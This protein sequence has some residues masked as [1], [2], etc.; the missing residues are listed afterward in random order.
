MR[1]NAIVS[2]TVNIDSTIVNTSIV[3]PRSEV[4]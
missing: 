2:T 3:V 4:S 1:S